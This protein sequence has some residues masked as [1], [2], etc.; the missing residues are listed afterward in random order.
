[1]GQEL[2][3]VGEG[4][5]LSFIKKNYG[6]NN[7]IYMGDGLYDAEILKNCFYGIAPHNATAEAKRNAAYITRVNS[8]EGA[9]LDACLHI[10]KKFF[11]TEYSEIFKRRYLSR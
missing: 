11:R 1:M 3:L 5:L 9:V 4:E 6:L 8:G 2:Y 7:T 10:L